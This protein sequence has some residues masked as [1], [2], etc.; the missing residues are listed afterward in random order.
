MIH[1]VVPL[2]SW[3]SPDKPGEGHGGRSWGHDEQAAGHN[4]LGTAI[5]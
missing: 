3:P 4:G 5:A 1:P 2:P